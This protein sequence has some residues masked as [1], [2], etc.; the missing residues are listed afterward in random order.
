MDAAGVLDFREPID[1][2]GLPRIVVQPRTTEAPKK[3]GRLRIER[4]ISVAFR[5]AKERQ[6]HT[7]AQRKAIIK[8]RLILTSV[9]D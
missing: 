5:A 6:K 9:G 2:N 8:N 7:F 4:K 3:I 1:L